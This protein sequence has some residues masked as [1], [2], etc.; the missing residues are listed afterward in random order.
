MSLLRLDHVLEGA[1]IEGLGVAITTLIVINDFFLDFVRLRSEKV[2]KL[3]F[4]VI[5]TFLVLTK[6]FCSG[7]VGH[8]VDISLS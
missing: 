1:T 8:D 3:L 4:E 2:V 5:L 6:V 7:Q